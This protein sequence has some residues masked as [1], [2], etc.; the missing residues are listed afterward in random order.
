MHLVQGQEWGEATTDTVHTGGGAGNMQ[1]S[2]G[3][4]SKSQ[5]QSLKDTSLDKNP[6]DPDLN[7]Q[8][9]LSCNT[10]LS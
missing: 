5:A 3:L 8:D 2:Q 7:D 6:L 4:T 9:P 1:S 10:I